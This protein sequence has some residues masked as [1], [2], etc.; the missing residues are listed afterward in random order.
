[1]QG[2][3]ECVDP[4]WWRSRPRADERFADPS[5]DQFFSK[6]EPEEVL[7]AAVTGTRD[8]SYGKST[9]TERQLAFPAIELSVLQ[10]VPPS[11]E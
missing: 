11:S 9:A 4:T 2:S 6:M 8:E 1:M 5:D 7:M 3:P 10:V